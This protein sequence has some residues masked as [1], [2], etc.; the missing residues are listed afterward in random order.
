MTPAAIAAVEASL[1]SVRFLGRSCRVAP[2]L[3]AILARVEAALHAE[4][5]RAQ[6]A[7]PGGAPTQTF[8]EW[9]GVRG[10]GGYRE[11]AGYHGKGRA[12]DI[13]YSRNG[14]AACATHTARGLVY[15]GESAGAKLPG[16]RKA[17]IAACGRACAAAGVLCDLSARR[18]GESTASVWDRWHV[19]S[20]A[21]RLYLAPYFPA[22]DDLDAGEADVL[23]EVTIPAQVMA[24][25]EALRVPLVVGQPVARPRMT[26]NPAKGLMDLRRAVVVALCDVGGMRWGACDFGA[27][28]SSDLM[29]FDDASR[30]P[31]GAV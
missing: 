21:V 11:G 2:K 23:P 13:N 15:G 24:D 9:H 26:R 14:Y 28:S 3:A 6:V 7:L 27:G 25:Y 20:E 5:Q 1:V 30:I 18:A 12:I 10:V 31:S 22:A 16:V 8:A 29:H 17:F 4:W 19:V